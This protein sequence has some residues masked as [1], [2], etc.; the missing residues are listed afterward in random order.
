M[1]DNMGD[2]LQ[3]KR[4]TLL[5][6]RQ[7]DEAGEC[8]IYWMQRSQR[9]ADNP[10]LD[11]AIALANDLS[12]PVVVYFG[13]F[14]AYPM[15]S[16]RAFT[17]MLEGL[18]ETAQALSERGIGF[19]LRRELPAEGIVRL[20]GELRAC[21]V[22][23]DE[24]YVNIGRVWRADAASKLGVRFIQVDSET[25]VPARVTDHEEWG[26]YTIRPKILKGLGDHLI[27]RPESKLKKP[28]KREVEG[29]DIT[30][31]LPALV[32]SLEVDQDAA[33]TPYFTGGLS[34][35]RE[36]LN[37]FIEMGLTRYG[38][39][40]NDIGAGVSSEL[41]PYLHFGQI[42]S[43]RVAL[44]VRDADAP[45]ESVDAFLEQLIVRRELAI[46][47]C[48]Y[49]PD[50]STMDAAP[51]WA[52]K[53]LRAHVSD[54][55]PEVFSLEELEAGST[56][57]DLWN[58]AQ[59]ELVRFG[60]VHPYMRIV[61]AKKLLEWSPTPEE[62]LARAI[63]LNDKYAIDGRDPNGY[64]NIAWCILGKHDRPFAERPIFGK[65]R[66]MTTEATKRKT[67]W[68]DYVS[69]VREFRE[70]QPETDPR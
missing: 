63:F 6:D 28:W 40:R 45:D 46:N 56:Y 53:S 38:S 33:P 48:L 21:A 41:S 51:D 27:D 16:A 70:V 44:V 25:V 49:N 24:D 19:V 20:A 66:Y 60:K 29:L 10:A 36:R 62:A 50:Y 34:K 26:A 17:F 5:S 15:A 54:P 22:V 57:D 4:V 32:S 52:A 42:A 2:D 31:D 55:R 9:A 69:R 12:K 61:W 64:A 37:R 1:Y 11:Y 8:V 39:E 18:R 59:L 67:H 68:Q 65:V 3:K 14:D 23:V 58:A 7:V 43:L 47:F 30:A 13:L 35:A